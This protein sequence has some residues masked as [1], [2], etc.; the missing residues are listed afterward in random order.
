MYRTHCGLDFKWNKLTIAPTTYRQGVKAS[1]DIYQACSFHPCS[2]MLSHVGLSIRFCRYLIVF[3]PSIKSTGAVDLW[4]KVKTIL[5]ELQRSAGLQKSKTP[6][7][8]VVQLAN[9]SLPKRFLSNWGRQLTSP[10]QETIPCKVPNIRWPTPLIQTCFDKLR[11]YNIEGIR[12]EDWKKW[13]IQVVAK[14]FQVLSVVIWV[15]RIYVNTSDLSIMS[16]LVLHSHSRHT[17]QSG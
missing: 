2:S 13:F 10:L 4:P 8:L 12:I 11:V 6:L 5:H 15:S 14:K 1:V 3:T 9:V 7:V 17:S 16:G